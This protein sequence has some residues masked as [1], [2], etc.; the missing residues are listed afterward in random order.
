MHSDRGSMA[1]E[2]VVLAPVILLVCSLIFAYGRVAQVNGKLEAGTRD[3]TRTATFSRTYDEAKARATRVLQDELATGSAECRKTLTVTVSDNFEPG[4]T[5]TVTATC[6][7]PISDAGLPGAPGTL[8]P[9][10]SFSSV[11]DPN[12]QAR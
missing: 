5:I 10:S 9:T 11:L 4:Q 6:N 3:A 7:Y 12:R 8:H 1:V 2:Y